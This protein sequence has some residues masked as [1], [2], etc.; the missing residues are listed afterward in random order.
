MLFS[1]LAFV[2]TSN[3]LG[4][5]GAAG[6]Q[7]E[8]VFVGNWKGMDIFVVDTPIGPIY[9]LDL[10]GGMLQFRVDP[11]EAAD[12][13][14]IEDPARI[15]SRLMTSSKVYL[16]YEEKENERIN[17]A[18]L[19]MTR[20]LRGRPFTL[21]TGLTAPY[22][23]NESSGVPYHDPWNVT[24]GEAAIYVKFGDSNEVQML[25]NTVLVTGNDL[26]NVTL[27]VTKLGL[28]MYRLI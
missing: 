12:E 1:T 4:G 18:V 3:M 15:Y 20:F 23:G 22:Q 26:H 10:G 2:L 19:E 17:Q 14:S 21:E 24:G 28:V 7:Q 5:G 27:A 9:S 16:L 8:P 25:N 13:I 6:G 11:Q